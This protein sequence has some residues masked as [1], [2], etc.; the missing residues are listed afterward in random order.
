MHIGTHFDYNKH[1]AFINT[2]TKIGT[3]HEKAPVITHMEV[4][5]LI[6]FF[7]EH[8]TIVSISDCKQAID[9]RYRRKCRQGLLIEPIQQLAITAHGF[10]GSKCF[11]LVDGGW[12]WLIDC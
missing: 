2:H 9:T 8:I 1:I 11:M 10:V 3:P 4:N 7:F 5:L 12:Q 6:Q